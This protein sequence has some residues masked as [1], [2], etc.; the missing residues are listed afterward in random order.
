MMSGLLITLEGIDGCGKS[1]QAAMLQQNLKERGVPFIVVREP[2]ATP[3]GEGIREILLQDE[4]T[5]SGQAEML[6][7]MAARAELVEGVILP[8]VTVGKVVV[9][10]R[11]T[12]STLAYQGYGGGLD[13]NW[14]RTLNHKVTAGLCPDLTLM[15]DLSVEEAAGRRGTCPDRMEKRDYYYHR[16]VRHGYLELARRE[17][18]RIYLIDA[19]ASALEQSLE[20]WRLVEALLEQKS[21]GGGAVDFR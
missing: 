7:Y 8:A 20:I 9:C 16:R 13:L 17:P 11:F 21:G 2:G 1:T 3:V 6:L 12:D 10:D 18:R 4:Y 14:I 15:L 19:S 5:L